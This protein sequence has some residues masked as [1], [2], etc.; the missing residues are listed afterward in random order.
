M[1][2]LVHGCKYLLSFKDLKKI[3]SNIKKKTPKIPKFLESLGENEK[4]MP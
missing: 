4:M 2:Y 1:I 3:I